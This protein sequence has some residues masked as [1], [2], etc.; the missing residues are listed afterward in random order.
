MTN[1]SEPATCLCIIRR[2]RGNR[3]RVLVLI[4]TLLAP[5]GCRTAN[6]TAAGLPQ[7]LRVPTTQPS[8][9]INL[10]R[11]AG[12]GSSTSQ[13]GPGDLLDVTIA[14]GLSDEQPEP[15]QIR[16]SDDGAASVPLIGPV[17]VSGLEPFQAEQRIASAAVERG[18][19]RQPYVTLTVAAQAVNRVT[20]LGAVAEPGVHELPRGA[21]NLANALGAAGGLSEE[22][23]TEVEILRQG[24]PSYLADQRNQAGPSAPGQVALASYDQPVVPPANP[25]GLTPPPLAEQPS[26][27][28]AP[29]PSARPPFGAQTIHIDLAQANQPVGANYDLGD[30]DVIMMLPRQKRFIHVTGLVNKPNQFEIPRDQSIHVLDAIAMAGGTSSP[31]ADKVYVIRQWNGMPQPAIIEVSIGKAKRNGDDNPLLAPGD[32]VS[33]E[34]TVATALVDTARNFFRVAVGLSGNLATF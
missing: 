12:D 8:S 16:V 20:V 17:S 5:A 2:L 18:V 31:V 21:S 11:M 10:A 25:L 34:S 27:L 29:A 3:L 13:I 22:A 1:R 14:S 33:V 15:V 7:P 4:L 26:D 9:A 30:G 24:S 23:G 28:G 32:L 19:Y 6:Y